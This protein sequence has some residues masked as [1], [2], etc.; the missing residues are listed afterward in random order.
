MSAAQFLTQ[1]TV[2]YPTCRHAPAQVLLE[3]LGWP[4]APAQARHLA[5]TWGPGGAPTAGRAVLRGP[6]Q[7]AAEDEL[8]VQLLTQQV[9][10]AA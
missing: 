9:V 10:R 7:R 3:G 8:R 6:G 4:Q 1:Q 5:T 2:Q